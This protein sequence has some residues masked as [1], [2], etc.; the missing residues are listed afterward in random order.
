MTEGRRRRQT[1]PVALSSIAIVAASCAGGVSQAPVD[2]GL[3]DEAPQSA[4][5]A[6]P[7]VPLPA[8]APPPSS[9]GGDGGGEQPADS[10]PAA[11]PPT[12]P[13]PEPTGANTR[14]FTSG[15][16]VGVQSSQPGEADPTGGSDPGMS[17][18][19]R[20]ESEGEEPPPASA[21]AAADPAGM[22]LAVEQ[23]PG[24]G[25]PGRLNA[26]TPNTFMSPAAG[27]GVGALMAAAQE[28]LDDLWIRKGA[29]RLD[30][31]IWVPG[32]S[33]RQMEAFAAAVDDL[34]TEPPAL[35]GVYPL[36]W[37]GGMDGAASDAPAGPS[38]AAD[39]DDL[40]VEPAAEGAEG[41]EAEDGPENPEPEEN[42]SLCVVDGA[43]LSPGDISRLMLWVPVTQNGESWAERVRVRQVGWSGS[44]EVTQRHHLMQWTPLNG[45]GEPAPRW[46]VWWWWWCST[47]AAYQP[48]PGGLDAAVDNQAQLRVDC[49]GS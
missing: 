16:A 31:L 2:N 14:P 26:W 35:R 45:L 17:A 32:A 48:D 43:S 38:G 42:G 10:P 24:G 46:R 40:A 44:I 8:F 6:P 30:A 5:T 36:H 11:P 27:D 22:V 41:A 25:C 49:G 37:I 12:S 20:G 29:A 7:G 15:P 13:A 21:Q 3:V 23:Q 33:K 28:T 4:W 9:P 19:S 1:C 18:P 47:A 34:R 39:A